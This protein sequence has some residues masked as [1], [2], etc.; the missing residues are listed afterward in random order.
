[1]TDYSSTKESAKEGNLVKI[2]LRPKKGESL[3]TSPSTAPP[4]VS[5]ENAA[6]AALLSEKRVPNYLRPTLSSSNTSTTQPKEKPTSVP[7]QLHKSKPNSANKLVIAIPERTA[8]KTTT[9]QTPQSSKPSTPTSSGRRP[10]WEPKQRTDAEKQTRS[11]N[12]SSGIG[13]AKQIVDNSAKTKPKTLTSTALFSMAKGSSPKQR[14]SLADVPFSKPPT[15][16]VEDKAFFKKEI[17]ELKKMCT[18]TRSENEELK[19]KMISLENDVKQRDSSIT[20]LSDRYSKLNTETNKAREHNKKLEE[21]I[22]KICSLQSKNNGWDQES[23]E[24][25]LLE[26]E[27]DFYVLKG[28]YEQTLLMIGEKMK[29]LNEVMSF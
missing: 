22:V 18:S 1:M 29:I 26:K 14:K 9:G 27:R 5:K 23:L 4:K 21:Q 24:R 28:R 13:I 11:L 6:A 20:E 2:T 8:N 16:V 25:E 12:K 7:P 15:K 17:A 10:L 3:P 19:Q